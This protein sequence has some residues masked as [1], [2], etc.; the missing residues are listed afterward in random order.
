MSSIENIP[1]ALRLQCDACRAYQLPLLYGIYAAE[2]PLELIRIEARCRVCGSHMQWVSKNALWVE[3]LNA[4]TVEREARRWSQRTKTPAQVLATV[5]QACWQTAEDHGFN[6]VTIDGITR[7]RSTGERAMLVVTELAEL[8][9]AVRKNEA[10][11]PSDHITGFTYREEEWADV[12]IRAFSHGI[13]DGVSA[14]RL[15]AAIIAKMAYNN[16]RPYR[17]GKVM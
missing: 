1:P 2:N 13:E 4:Q 8:F 15:A 14:E 6:E 17:H 10:D 5:A 16:T 11:T 7:P 12:V 9:E 3:Q